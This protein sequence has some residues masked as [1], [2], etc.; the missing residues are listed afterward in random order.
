MVVRVRV[1]T[2]YS[3]SHLK[4][5][6]QSVLELEAKTRLRF[7][8]N[9][10]WCPITRRSFPCEAFPRDYA[11]GHV[12]ARNRRARKRALVHRHAET[13]RAEKIGALSDSNRQYIAR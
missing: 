5:A 1:F 12:S 10:G 7:S 11:Q 13:L 3:L 8:D 2:S 4:E 9:N 6:I